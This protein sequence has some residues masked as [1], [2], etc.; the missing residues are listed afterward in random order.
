MIIRMGRIEWHFTGGTD[1]ARGP[2][3]GVVGL[4]AATARF[5]LPI[6]EKW[7]AFVR[8]C[9]AL[10]VASAFAAGL[11]FLT[12]CAPKE[13]KV[14]VQ[15]TEALGAVLAEETVRVAGAKKRVAIIS[16]ANW[17]PTSAAEEVFTA[18]LKRQ[19]FATFIVKSADLGDPMRRGPVGL[20]SADFLEALQEAAGAGA[21]VSFA[22]APLLQPGDA[23]RLSPGHP[24]VLVV[25]TAMLGKVRGV[26]ANQV[27]LGRLL[28][29]RII[30]LA[31][32]DDSHES[33]AQSPGKT[34]AIHQ[35][36]AQ[37]YLILRS[38]N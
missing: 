29:A 1:P 34:D 5:G 28:D 33:A 16:P 30:Q 18:A 24:P 17:G 7:S 32:I 4:P 11:A 20:K 21:V 6:S 22:G 38:P 25:A 14:L 23:A 2:G 37:H 26:W 10:W 3:A 31:I 19:G 9:N 35:L 15:S 27:Q 8:N 36:F 13:T 12:S